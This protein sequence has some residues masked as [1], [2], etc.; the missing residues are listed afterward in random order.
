MTLS[1]PISYETKSIRIMTW[2]VEWLFME[3]ELPNRIIQTEEFS[4]IY[5]K[6]QKVARQIITLNPDICCLQEVS[7]M[8]VLR[9]LHNIILKN[10][11]INYHMYIQKSGGIHKIAILSKFVIKKFYDSNSFIRFSV[12]WKGNEF[13]MYCVH[14]RSRI[15]GVIETEKNR[16]NSL[17]KL[18]NDY[19]RFQDK[20][21]MILG[22]FNDNFGSNSL[23]YLSDRKLINLAYTKKFVASY[24]AKYTYI[25]DKN[26]PISISNVRDL[27]HIF[28]N[29]KMYK[30][31][32]DVFIDKS[33]TKDD[34][35]MVSDHY[36]LVSIIQ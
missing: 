20:S 21:V 4:D 17:K 23:N 26:K 31:I 3:S 27:D 33:T 32:L 35:Q 7:S 15:N 6:S 16:I 36:P 10:Y 24:L 30:N 29:Y 13:I 1:M 2:N 12:Y 22:D 9:L 25:I 5:T 14:L 34:E 11:R 18:Y 28:T 8:N 19:T